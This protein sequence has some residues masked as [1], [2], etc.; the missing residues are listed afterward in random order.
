MGTIING[1][2]WA[3]ACVNGNIVSGLVKNGAV[4]YKKNADLLQIND[5]NIESH[6]YSLSV[7]NG[8]ITLNGSWTSSFNGELNFNSNVSDLPL[9]N[10]I[11]KISHISS[12]NN[13]TVA[14]KLITT[15]YV[16]VVNTNFYNSDQEIHFS[17]NTPAARLY[18]YIAPQWSYQN[19]KFK[20][21]IFKKEV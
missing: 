12:D 16:Q 7:Q 13:Q 15:N 1:N 6:G 9:G 10:Y 18:L 3:G 11:C 4:F 5:M 17:L 8:I 19:K 2:K 21:E 20:I 14:V